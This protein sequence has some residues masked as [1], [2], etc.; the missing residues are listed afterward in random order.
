MF[1]A[2]KVW[3]PAATAAAPFA[4]GFEYLSALLT[5]GAAVALMRYGVGVIP[6]IVACGLAGAAK[7]LIFA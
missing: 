4:G 6:V 1:F 7:T 2:W 5:A 3:W